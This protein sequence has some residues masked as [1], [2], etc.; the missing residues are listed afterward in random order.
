MHEDNDI[1]FLIHLIDKNKKNNVDQQLKKHDLT[2]SQSQVLGYL[3][4]NE[5]QLSQK[6]L[7]EKMNVSHPTMVGLV[8]RLGTN[9]FVKT[10]YCEDDKRN[11]IV[12]LTDK[13]LDFHKDVIR[14]ID[15]SNRRM[16]KNI[17]AEERKVLADLL[18]KMADNVSSDGDNKC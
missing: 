15:E 1:G 9:G 11:K 4:R 7:Q 6:T 5:G 12:F 8:K 10:A 13:A 3:G 14:T 16:L 17:T 2:F 18:K